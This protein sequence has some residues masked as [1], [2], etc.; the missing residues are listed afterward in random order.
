MA[1]C[2]LNSSIDTLD[3]NPEHIPEDLS[4]NDQESVVELLLE[5]VLGFENAIV[6]YDDHDTEEHTKKKTSKI[7]FFVQYAIQQPY[8]DNTFNLRKQQYPNF[9]DCLPIGYLQLSTP[10]PKI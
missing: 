4:F 8:P 9:K 2:F 5:K 3:P 1:L 6:E 7:D 10:P